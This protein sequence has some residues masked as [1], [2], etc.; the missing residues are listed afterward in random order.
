MKLG[1][2]SQVY[3]F[4]LL[5][6]SILLQQG[7]G[8]V[9]ASGAT[10]GILAPTFT[11]LP[12]Y[13]ELSFV[14]DQ[15]KITSLDYQC[16]PGTGLSTFASSTTNAPTFVSVIDYDDAAVPGN[17]T[18]LREYQ[19]LQLH[20]PY[21]PWRRTVHPQINLSTSALAEAPVSSPWLDMATPAQPH[22][23]LKIGIEGNATSGANLCQWRVHLRMTVQCR[24]VR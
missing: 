10:H 4:S 24:R 12:D 14:Y 23:G 8:E 7:T 17:M 19:S 20:D 11:Q 6:P 9:L 13:T 21:R 15:Y 22:Y 3:T 18:V 16:F 1:T 2:D 5:C